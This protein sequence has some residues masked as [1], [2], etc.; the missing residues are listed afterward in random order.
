MTDIAT[1]IAACSYSTPPGWNAGPGRPQPQIISSYEGG[2]HQADLSATLSK[3]EGRGEY[4]DLSCIVLVPAL[5]TVP[6]KAVASWWNLYFPPNQ[7]VVKLFALGM[8]VGAAYSDTIAMVLAHPD[9][10]QYK[11]LITLEHDNVP[12]PDGVVRLLQ[13]MEAHPEFAC[14]GGLYFTKGE[15]GVA[16][17]W[18]NPNEFPLNFKPQ[19]PR[20][21]EVVECC[22]TGM[23][24]NAFRLAMFKDERLRRPWFK[25][26]ASQAE[27][28]QTQDLY[29][30]TD[31]RKHGYRCAIDCTI[32]VGHVD[33]Q[34]GIVW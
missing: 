20:V 15:A 8:E 1:E 29:A 30:W 9:L 19:M 34:T 12:P 28:L 6:T 14:I 7:K 23:G 18:G 26:T 27:G 16:Q 17:I 4:R 33:Q 13:Q 31:F 5:G 22:G 10:S 3:L 21:G 25:T 11:Y 24:F 32:A 2:R